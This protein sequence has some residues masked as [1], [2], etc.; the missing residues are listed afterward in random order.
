[1]HTE[2]NHNP[3]YRPENDL[4]L[5]VD[6]NDLNAFGFYF[7]TGEACALS[8]RMLMLLS[9]LGAEILRD[10]LGLPYDTKF[11][12]PPNS[13][14]YVN[15]EKIPAVGSFMMPRNSEFVID[16]AIFILMRMGY[17]HVIQHGHMLIGTNKDT[18]CPFHP[19]YNGGLSYL[20]DGIVHYN[21]SAGRGAH[22]H[23]GTK[24][25]HAATGGVL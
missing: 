6:Y 16:L 4:I 11:N 25:I 2:Y 14:L 21:P 18:E 17:R 22:P 9:D 12:D 10:Y 3:V 13:Y 23:I 19:Q 20:Q 1:M 5:N 8:R 15:G 24:N 7:L